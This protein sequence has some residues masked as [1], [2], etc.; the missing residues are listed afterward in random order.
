MEESAFCEST[1]HRDPVVGFFSAACH[2][3]GEAVRFVRV[4]L[5]RTVK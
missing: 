1:G 5:G 2:A 3:A 4:L